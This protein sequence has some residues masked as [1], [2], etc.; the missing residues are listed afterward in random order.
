MEVDIASKG[1]LCLLPDP[2]TCFRLAKYSQKQIIRLASGASLALID[3]VTSGRMSIGEEWAFSRYFSLN[4]IWVDGVRIA[5]DAL[6]LE[7]NQDQLPIPSTT[8]VRTLFN[9]LSPYGC[10]A[11]IFLYGPL[12]QSVIKTIKSDYLKISVFKMSCMDDFLWSVSPMDGDN[13]C[14]IRVAG[15]ET[16]MVNAW[17]RN[18]LSG[19]SDVLGTDVYRKAFPL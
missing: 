12:V 17:L 5:K 18:A 3:S 6:L 4:E 7:E 10:Y 8:P 13:G 1:F 19:L 9:R 15:K 11:T 16:E 14:I 2:V